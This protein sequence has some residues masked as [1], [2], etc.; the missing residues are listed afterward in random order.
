MP[1][2]TFFNLESE[3][4]E[5]IRQTAYKEF[6]MNDYRN[7]SVSTIVKN[8]GL[9]KGSF[10]R[11]FIN[12][13]DLYA[14]LLEHSTQLRMKSINNLVA[15]E[16]SDFFS[17]L[18]ANFENKIEFD[19]AHPLE[20]IFTYRVLLETHNPEVQQL[21]ADFKQGIFKYVELMLENFVQAGLLRQNIDIQLTTFIVFQ[22]QV[23]LFEYLAAYEG[24]DFIKN[25][26]EGKTVFAIEK[27][28]IMGIVLKMVD[29]IKLGIQ[30]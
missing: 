26:A 2:Q 10:Y 17:I 21:I 11:Y 22:I 5:E 14:Y 3:R 24:V 18:I 28:K 20:S 16:K 4:Q 23:G 9:A 12:K 27:E 29:I 7:A 15:H 8:L 1:Q 13:I 19:I 25:I 6:A 30:P